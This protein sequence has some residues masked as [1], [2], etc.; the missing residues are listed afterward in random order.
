MWS[1]QEITGD[2]LLELD[3]NL[4]KTE[5]GIMAF[6]KRVRIANAIIELRGQLSSG[7]PSFHSQGQLFQQSSPETSHPSFPGPMLYHPAST[8]PHLSQGAGSYSPLGSHFMPGVGI[9]GQA[10]GHSR[11]YS[12]S[13]QSQRSIPG[14]MTMPPGGM[15][16]LYSQSMPGGGVP[17]ST[18]LPSPL[19][20]TFGAAWASA[21]GV[22][23]NPSATNGHR[24]GTESVSG[25]V[26]SRED[27][28]NDQDKE[29]EGVGLGLVVDEERTRRPAH[30]SLSPS[31]GALGDHV[32]VVNGDEDGVG[33]EEEDRGHVSEV[34]FLLSALL[35]VDLIL[36]CS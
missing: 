27:R 11:T 23:A 20:A 36:A 22:G 21:P 5:I 24:A 25:S 15:P 17:P 29:K 32:H 33:I 19:A 35:M 16:M 14:S 18:S 30:L 7:S 4:L 34:R 13:Q 3:A 31:D 26:L 8:P 6:G 2:V 28:E 1:E 12:A 10:L 9:G